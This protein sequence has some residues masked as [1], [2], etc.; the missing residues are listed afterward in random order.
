MTIRK[1][2]NPEQLQNSSYDD[3][4]FELL[5]DAFST[6]KSII[7]SWKPWSWKTTSL[8]NAISFLNENT[9]NTIYLDKIIVFIKSLLDNNEEFFIENKI[10]LST[11]TKKLQNQLWQIWYNSKKFIIWFSKL[12]SIII[13]LNVRWTYVSWKELIDF[14]INLFL[15]EERKEWNHLY[16]IFLKRKYIKLL[17]EFLEEYEPIN[18]ILW[19]IFLELEWYIKQHIDQAEDYS[20]FNIIRKFNLSWIRDLH[21][22]ENPVEYIYDKKYINFFQYD[23]ETHFSEPWDEKMTEDEATAVKLDRFKYMILRDAPDIVFLWE[24]RSKTEIEFFSSISNTWNPVL[25]TMHANSWFHNVVKMI[26]A[27]DSA[28]FALNNVTT[29]LSYSINLASYFFKW[30][31]PVSDKISPF[32]QYYDVLD[33]TKE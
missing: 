31:V 29:N 17:S 4:Y 1:L 23:L 6:K 7:I 12:R 8:I 26:E 33:L 9:Y 22:L 3:K 21:I 30:L 32:I 28:S 2:V 18:R 27:S 16:Q 14:L 25:T 5:L 10:P 20:L 15:R 24:V 11:T 13:N 19:Q